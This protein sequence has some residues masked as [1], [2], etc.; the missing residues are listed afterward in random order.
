MLDEII[1]VT[2]L[3][4]AQFSLFVILN[5]S[6]KI[7]TSRPMHQFV[8]LSV[9]VLM[10]LSLKSSIR[11]DRNV[12]EMAILIVTNSVAIFQISSLLF[13]GISLGM[14]EDFLAAEKKGKSFDYPNEY[15]QKLAKNI[16]Q[17]RLKG[18]VDL[19]LIIS[20]S[21]LN[22]KATKRGLLFGGLFSKLRKMILPRVA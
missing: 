10:I 7:L 19:K 17:S 16:W 2:M 3:F 14:L 18:L 21:N 15:T 22:L 20:V 1:L 5:R 8:N 12:Y 11:F 6:I 4:L 9:M 13:R